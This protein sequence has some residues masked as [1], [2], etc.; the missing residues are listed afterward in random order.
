MKHVYFIISF[1]SAVL[2]FNNNSSAQLQAYRLG[3][4]NFR[5]SDTLGGTHNVLYF[6]MMLQHLN[7]GVSGDFYYAAGQYFLNFNPIIANGGVLTYRIVDSDLPPELRPVNASISG[8]LL[9]LASNLPAPPGYLI[10][11]S[12]PG[13]KIVRMSLRTSAPTFAP[14]P[15]N[16]TWR[17][18]PPQEVLIAAFDGI[19]AYLVSENGSYYVD[20]LNNFV[21]INL[22]NP[23]YNSSDNLSS[24]NI[25]WNKVAH[26]KDYTIQISKDSLLNSIF[27]SDSLITDTSRT[28]SDIGLGSKYYW[29]LKINDSSGAVYYSYTSKFSTKKIL[30][31][32]IDNAI[33]QNQSVDFL[34]NKLNDSV[35]KYVLLVSKDSLMNSFTNSDTIATDTSK[36]I[37]GFNYNSK[38]FWKLKILYPAG[39]TAVTEVRSFK[40]KKVII[41]QTSPLNNSIN[42]NLTVNFIWQPP[43]PNISNKFYL[44]I[45]NDSVQS[46]VIYSDSI[47]GITGKVAGGFALNTRYFWSISVKDSF[48]NYVSSEI[49]NFRTG[50]LSVNLYSPVN[51][52][53]GVSTSP[54]IIWRK[55]VIDVDKYKLI[56]SSDSLQTDIK[57]NETLTDTF[58]YISGLDFE[59]KYYWSVTASDSLG[60]SKTSAV[61]NFKTLTVLVSPENNAVDVPLN[62]VLIWRKALINNSSYKFILSRD[63]LQT[64]IVYSDSAITDTFKHITGLIFDKKYYWS[65][66]AKDTAGNTSSSPVWNFKSTTFLYS[67]ANNSF[68]FGWTSSFLFQW[69]RIPSAIYYKLEVAEDPLFEHLLFIDSLITDSNR[70]VITLPDRNWYYWKISVWNNS[71]YFRVSDVWNFRREFPVP[72]EI[73]SFTSSV[74][75]NDVRL[76]WATANEINNSGF[77]IERSDVK[78]QMSDEWIRIG[79]VPGKGSSTIV[80][81]YSYTD[82]NVST[83]KYAYRLKQIDFNGNFEY[84]NLIDEVN[85]GIPSKYELSQNYP[86]P[87]NPFTNFKF[88]IPESGF[89]TLKIYNTSGMEVATIV[90]E[91][92]NA[93]YYS[94]NFNA[95]S[96]SSGV[97][98]YTI[99]ANN[100]VQT[101]KMMLVK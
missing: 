97:Y 94:I 73:Q 18:S 101:K 89:V 85:I 8:N 75:S 38:Y 40:T 82:R 24:I 20:S 80:Q 48:N 74:I 13:T 42:N 96:L 67:P 92:M 76:N 21:N 79:N 77:D 57:I 29:R 81:S 10:S 31:S 72:V 87:F 58:K 46:D 28:I 63:S 91:S 55:P 34:W 35:S 15:L 33:D 12:Y 68:F 30:I 59:K 98:F 36:T 32:P 100:F 71:G 51:N 45:S 5:F 66:T 50:I 78:A 14:V 62:P 53:V 52:S 65:I 25:I 64:D 70:F 2:L 56:I 95:S 44:K 93:G 86:N 1:L 17:S 19:L 11:T 23:I 16:L 26:A 3:A 43:V 88:E 54:L 27:I 69:Y 7:P 83:G 49:W 6:N 4:N 47:T 61:W 84:F 39:S 60:T 41:A 99:S 9:R 37:S 90:S 22:I